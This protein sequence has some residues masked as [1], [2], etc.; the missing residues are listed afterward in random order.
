[1]AEVSELGENEVL[2][3]AETERA[4]RAADARDGVT[5]ESGQDSGE[6]C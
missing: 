2:L 4:D 6:L 1:V 5:T 3:G